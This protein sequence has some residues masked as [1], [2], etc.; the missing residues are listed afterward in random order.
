VLSVFNLGDGMSVMIKHGNYYTIYSNL[1]SVSVSKGA[2]IKT[3]QVIG[4]AGGDENG[5]GKIDFL[6]M[7]DKKN[8]NP[9]SWL[10]R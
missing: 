7:I 9:M 6:L 5:G 8:V 1:S 2:T 10:H 3:S 4:K